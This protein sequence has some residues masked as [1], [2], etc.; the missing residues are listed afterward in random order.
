MTATTQNQSLDLTS[1]EQL[2]K[3][4]AEAALDIPFYD[5]DH[6][7]TLAAAVL[8]DR[9][10][11]NRS[12]ETQNRS[13]YHSSR[14]PSISITDYMKRVGKYSRC[15][16]ECMII[17]IVYLDRYVAKSQI[18]VTFRNAHRLIIVAV[19]VAA[20]IRDDIY[21]SNSYYG[22]IGGL[23]LKELND[24]E[25]D[26]VHVLEWTTF[27][28]PT[29]YHMYLCEIARRYS[30]QI[31]YGQQPQQ[32]M[33]IEQE[34]VAGGQVAEVA[35]QEGAVADQ[36]EEDRSTKAAPHVPKNPTGSPMAAGK[37]GAYAGASNSGSDRTQ[38]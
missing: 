22:S 8:Q 32:P 16:P 21:Y 31:S 9:C 14:V 17:A 23:Q 24:L 29:E 6:L 2:K 36:Q 26:F 11:A 15:S 13:R 4:Q 10:A 33:E 18:P 30:S 27:V 5:T 37:S 12:L 28:T 34:K 38:E 1:E 25:M 20:K 7:A 35:G 3:F 19:L